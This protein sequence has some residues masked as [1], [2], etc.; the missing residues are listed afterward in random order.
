MQESSNEN[1]AALQEAPTI[2][3]VASPTGQMIRATSEIKLRQSQATVA[4]ELQ[5][6]T[7]LMQSEDKHIICQSE[8][9]DDRAELSSPQQSIGNLILWN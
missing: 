5:E 7:V 2:D 8:S 1:Q 9:N 4:K 6:N 3:I